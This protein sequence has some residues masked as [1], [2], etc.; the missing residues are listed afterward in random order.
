M[1]VVHTGWFAKWLRSKY[2]VITWWSECVEEK[3]RQEKGIPCGTML[4]Y[5]V[6]PFET[7]WFHFSM[8]ALSEYK[9]GS[10]IGN[11]SSNK[12]GS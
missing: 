11:A 12:A 8:A 4:A 7:P 3:F 10:S 1:S 9:C 5:A 2:N 6:R